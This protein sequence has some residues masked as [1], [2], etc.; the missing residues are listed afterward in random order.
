MICGSCGKG[1]KWQGGY[2]NKGSKASHAE[3][4]PVQLITTQSAAAQ[5]GLRLS[6]LREEIEQTTKKGLE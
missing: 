1:R 4:A 6:A 3:I 2:Y 5:G